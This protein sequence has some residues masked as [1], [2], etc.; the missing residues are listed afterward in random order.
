[1]RKVTAHL[2]SSI[3]GN[4][5]SPHLFQFDAFG[6]EEGEMMGAAFTNVT[7]AV[8]GR[9]IWSEW[10]EYWPSND[11]PDDFGAIINPLRKHVATSTL[12]ADSVQ[13]WENSTVIDTDVVEF[14]RGLRE[15]EGGE[16]A[17]FGL[18]VIRELLQAGLLD[19]L[20]LTVHPAFGGKGRRLF[21]GFDD[22][23]RLELVDS[24]VTTVGNAI[25]T[26]RKRA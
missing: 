19:A 17:A 8:M 15:G 18:T 3:D 12:G 6:P 24:Q 14:V 7:D 2:F 16:I 22:P 20:T 1:M 13:K 26:Y 9:V 4:V 5:E 25:L 21:D 10:A 23:F 11:A